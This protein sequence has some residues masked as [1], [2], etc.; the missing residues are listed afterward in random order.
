M[1]KLHLQTPTFNTNERGGKEKQFTK[2]MVERDESKNKIR[3]KNTVKYLPLTSA[4][5]KEYS[6]RGWCIPIEGTY[7][8]TRAVAPST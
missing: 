5:E 8:S 6:G 2:N 7:S 1:E 3:N 4:E